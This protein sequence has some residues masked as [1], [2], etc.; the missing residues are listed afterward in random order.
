MSKVLKRQKTFFTN[1]SKLYIVGVP[2][3]NFD[4]I[5]IRAIQTLQMVD[6]IYCEDTRVTQ[7]LLN[8]LHISKPL[9]SY[10]TFNENELT[11]M[12]IEQIKMGKN[13]AIVSDAGM[14]II[15]DPGFVAVRQAIQD[16]IDVV[17][18]PG[19]SAFVTAL[20]GS[21]I[22]SNRIV[23]T[24]FLNSNDNKRKKELENLKD[25]EET[26]ILYE[27]PH[28]IKETLEMLKELMPNRYMCLA[29]ELTKQYEE[30]LHGTP[31]EI[32]NLID[33]IKGEIVLI[34]EGATRKE[35]NEE[36]NSGSIEDHMK[37]YLTKGLDEKNA[38]KMVAKDREVSKS[39]I[40][41]YLKKK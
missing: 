1:C 7:K 14:P 4:D 41:Q 10:H 18:I 38:M 35:I 31:A 20:V 3:G 2:I 32:L 27:S 28:R 15:S 23:F 24:G 22:S 8:Y 26:L 9:K 11:N 25:I 30:Y 37:Y 12:L 5:S 19:P 40:Y 6:L 16:E 34:I 17:V 21:G 29:R 13:I 39:Q 36:L 33:E